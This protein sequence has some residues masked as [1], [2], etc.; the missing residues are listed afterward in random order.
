MSQIIN[1]LIFNNDIQ[2]LKSLLNLW[3]SKDPSVDYIHHL[4]DWDHQGALG[5]VNNQVLSL[6][7][8]LHTC[9]FLNFSYL[10][11]VCY[12]RLDI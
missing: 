9:S 2:N 12:G 10:P 5:T 3:K 7:P 8:A 4:D 11:S 1:Q 6:A